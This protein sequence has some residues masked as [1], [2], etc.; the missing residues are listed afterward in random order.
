MQLLKVITTIFSLFLGYASYQFDYRLSTLFACFG[1]IAVLIL[2]DSIPASSKSNLRSAV[3]R[4]VP[5]FSLAGFSV[6]ILYAQYSASFY[7]LAAS[8][9]S[10]LFVATLSERLICLI[11]AIFL[12]FYSVFALRVTENEQDNQTG[13]IFA[14]AAKISAFTAVLFFVYVFAYYLNSPQSDYAVLLVG[15]FLVAANFL[16]AIVNLE[17]VFVLIAKIIAFFK[18]EPLKSVMPLFTISSVASEATLK[19]SFVSTVDERFGID[20][21]KSEMASYFAA[22]FEPSILCALIF[23]WMSTSVIIVPIDKEA[24]VR[25]FG[26]VSD[27]GAAVPGLHFKLPWPFSTVAFYDSKM[28]KTIDVGF[29][30]GSSQ[31]HLIWAKQHS[32]S[33]E[34]LIVGDGVELINIDCRIYYR[35]NNLVNYVT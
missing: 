18:K 12:Y 26:V 22:I 19:K 2:V 8:D 16:I 34:N 6:L 17:I 11:S 31:S 20:L 23:F 13:Q 27:K 14:V 33:N 30:A 15:Y 9:N 28:I 21:S 3:F 32:L 10:S 35:I 4:F 25:T 5:L 24:I 7:S 29:E 1:L